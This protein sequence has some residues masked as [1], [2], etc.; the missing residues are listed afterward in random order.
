MSIAEVVDRILE[1]E[2]TERNRKTRDLWRWER[3]VAVPHYHGVPQLSKSAFTVGI[4]M[5]MWAELLGFN[6]IAFYTIPEVYYEETLKIKLYRH[7]YIK[8]DTPLTKDIVIWPGAGFEESIFGLEQVYRPDTDPWVGKRTLLEERSNLL[9]MGKPDFYE[10]G[11][12]PQL[13]S[14]YDSIDN[15][16]RKHGMNAVFPFWQ[17]G[18][19]GIALRLRG[20][21]NL[22]MDMITA[23]SFVKDLMEYVT[24]SRQEW[25]KQRANFLGTTVEKGDLINDDVDSTM[26]SPEFY[27]EF[28]LPYEKQLSSFHRG[29]RYWHSCA[30][31][32]NFYDL[33]VK[34][35]S[36]DL[37]DVGPWS[38]VKRALH[39]TQGS[40]PLEIRL[41]PKKVNIYTATDE[42]I[43]NA[44]NYHI[45]RCKE[46]DSDFCIRVG[47]LSLFSGLAQDINSIKR[48]LA[49]ARDSGKTVGLNP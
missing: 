42:N 14:F 36:I 39:A 27:E 43:R 8:D 9:S 5:P 17:K 15:M 45:K 20:A 29:I 26:I 3:P 16:A 47:G 7:L 33:I 37:L 38:D 46:F 18:P 34:A 2:A 41:H 19:F 4:E 24:V 25:T 28:V 35:G 21:S 6:L 13:H 32:S 49:V 40:I 10:S 12:M 31:V 11:Y 22:F 23:P 1:L 30:N 48:F 44:V